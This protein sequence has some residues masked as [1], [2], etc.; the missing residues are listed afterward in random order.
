[1]PYLHQIWIYPIKAL[2]GV[3]VEQATLLESGAIQND[4]RFAIFDV[5]GKYVNGKNNAL[6]HNLRTTYDLAAQVVT[7]RGNTFPLVAH[8]PELE[9]YLSG[10]FGERVYVR[11]NSQMGFPDDTVA[12]GPTV[13]STATLETVACWFE[14]MSVEQARSRL[15]MN[16]EI[17]DVPAF[18]EDQLFGDKHQTVQ[19]QLG[20]ICLQGINPCQRCIVPTRD[21]MTG[22]AYPQFQRIF[23]QKRRQT[24]PAWVNPAR[25][26]HYYRLGVNTKLSPESGGK[27]LSRQDSVRRLS[28]L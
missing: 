25:F 9:E 6:V 5:H 17:G 22:D 19:F 27:I 10:Y 18:W 26:N 16:L 4:R 1:M 14:G 15:R 7:L 2:D 13:I 28:V 23:V 24:L 20:S 12:N 3:A 21:A 11:E 8:H